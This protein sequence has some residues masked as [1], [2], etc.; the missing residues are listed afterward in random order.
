MRFKKKNI[1]IFLIL[2]FLILGVIFKLSQ[3]LINDTTGLSQKIKY[4]VPQ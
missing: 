3:N 4:L 1:F 2:T